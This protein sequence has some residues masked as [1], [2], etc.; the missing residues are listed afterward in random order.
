M[1]IGAITEIPALDSWLA[2]RNLGG[3]WQRWTGRPPQ[4]PAFPSYPPFLWKWADI[5]YGLM[6]AGRLVS[7][8]QTGELAG[9]LAG[10][11]NL[12]LT[13]PRM[14]PGTQP[15]LQLGA[16]ILMPG[17]IA[18]AHRHSQVSVAIEKSALMAKKSPR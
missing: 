18:E 3:S 7:M 5:H 10:R 17:E 4:V 14:R 2:E 11:K 9:R 16:Q 13:N 6:M 12:G 1:D 8:D 15:T